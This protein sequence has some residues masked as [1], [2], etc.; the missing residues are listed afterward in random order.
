M[1]SVCIS[2]AAVLRCSCLTQTQK[3]VLFVPAA[4]ELLSS[5]CLVYFKWRSGRS[6]SLPLSAAFQCWRCFMSRIHLL[7]T[8][9][10]WIYFSLALLELLSVI[11]PLSQITPNRIRA[12][13][14]GIGALLIGLYTW[15][16]HGKSNP[17][18]SSFLPLFLYTLF[19]YLF[20]SKHLLTT[21]PTYVRNVA[22]VAL[23]FSLPFIIATNEVAS[24]VGLQTSEHDLDGT[25]IKRIHKTIF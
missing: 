14:I 17:G 5:T 13:D 23:F 7:L 19:L 20:T 1:G 9:E 15:S 21:L 4:L 12:I 3:V 2:S 16:W 22:K 11:P 18:I 10:G 25:W 6:G 8:A 24:V